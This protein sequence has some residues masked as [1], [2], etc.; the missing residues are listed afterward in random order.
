MCYVPLK[1]VLTRW[2]MFQF[3]HDMTD[4]LAIRLF[5]GTVR[6]VLVNICCVQPWMPVTLNLLY[7]HD[8]TFV[9]IPCGKYHLSRQYLFQ[10][11]L[12]KTLTVA[13]VVVAVYTISKVPQNS[14]LLLI[15]TNWVGEQLAL[16]CWSAK[17]ESADI[18]VLL[19]LFHFSNLLQW[20][21]HVSV[22]WQHLKYFATSYLRAIGAT[23]RTCP[24][25][26]IILTWSGQCNT[27]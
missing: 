20:D 2:R 14:I 27:K 4:Q 17:T 1:I 26:L 5:M 24:C 11:R 25:R 19:G 18:F 9:A 8:T 21:G 15:R 12:T 13:H 6:W 7:P 3:W 16:A 22:L 10:Q 23:V